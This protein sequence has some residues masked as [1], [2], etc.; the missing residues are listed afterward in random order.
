[1][2]YVDWQAGMTI[3]AERLRAITPGVWQTWT[4]TWTTTTGASTP[5]YGNAVL[6]CSYMQAGKLCIGRVLI[7]FGSTTSFG[8]GSTGDNWTFSLPVTAAGTTLHAGDG[9]IAQSSIGT[10]MG[11]RVRLLDTT[12]FGLETSTGRVD[13]TAVTGPNWGLVDSLSPWSWGSGN[14]VRVNFSYETAT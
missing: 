11:V 7:S 13:A 9:E 10:R 2:T 12:S 4:P 3:T 8:G 14:T 6:D 1:M 5:L